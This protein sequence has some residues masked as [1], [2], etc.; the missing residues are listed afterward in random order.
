MEEDIERRNNS[1][2]DE[3]FVVVTPCSQHS[4]ISIEEVNNSII[5]HNIRVGDW[6]DFVARLIAMADNLSTS[7]TQE[8][9]QK[10]VLEAKERVKRLPGLKLMCID[11]DSDEIDNGKEET[12]VVKTFGGKKFNAESDEGLMAYLKESVVPDDSL[13]SIS[14]PFHLP[15]PANNWETVENFVEQKVLEYRATSSAVLVRAFE[16]GAWL[17]FAQRSLRKTRR[18]GRKFRSF[19]SFMKAKGIAKS[20]GYK[21]MRFAEALCHHKKLLRCCVSERFF[22]HHLERIVLL[23][24][25]YPE[26]SAIWQE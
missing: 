8:N 17:K 23:L 5:A 7:P 22:L 1:E 24:Q 25:S 3:D 12:F 10:F 26:F 18:N 21:M 15:S 19:T 14:A 20:T 4:D 6:M 9:A 11:E 13:L 2:F 16:L